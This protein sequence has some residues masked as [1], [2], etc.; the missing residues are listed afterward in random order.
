MPASRSAAER[1][2]RAEGFHVQRQER[3]DAR[4]PDRVINWQ[5]T[6]MY[7]VLRQVGS[8]VSVAA[9]FMAKRL[10]FG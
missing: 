6:M 1:G 9:G 2:H 3:E 4:K 8:G 5:N 10:T 7:R